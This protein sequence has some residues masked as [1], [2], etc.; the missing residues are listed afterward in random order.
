MEGATTV[1]LLLLVV[2][3]TSMAAAL[4]PPDWPQYRF[5]ATHNAV[6]VNPSVPPLPNARFHTDNEIK[7]NPVIVGNRLYVG[8]HLTGGLFAFNVR[9]VK[10]LW[11]DN[12]PWFRHAPNW[13]H[14]DMI[15]VAGRIFVGYGNR[16]FRSAQVRGTGE[17]GVLALN[18][19]TGATVWNHPT[20]G[21]V[22]PTPAYW[23]GALYVATGGGQLIALDPRTGRKRWQL[24]LPGWVSMSSPAIYHGRLYVGVE[25]A[26]VGV[27]LRTHKFLWKYHDDATFTDVPPAVSRDGKTVVITG[28]KAYSNTSQ[29]E[30]KRYPLAKGYLQFIYAFNAESGR[31]LWKHLMGNGPRQRDDTAGTPT[32]AGGT[33]YVGSP[34]THAF[35]AYQVATG[36]LLWRAPVAAMVKGAPAV[37]AGRVYFGDIAGFL[38]VLNASTGNPLHRSNG[39][40]IAPL[41]L[42]GS[43]GGCRTAL[44]PNGPVIIDQDVFV[45]S[46]DG[47]VYRISIP[48]WLRRPD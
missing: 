34:Y 42:G 25:N 26:V 28:M 17:S 3:Q 4:G 40:A 31:L 8:N 45:A 14:S 43:L 12:Y 39:K 44:A 15:A 41:K 38:H 48:G 1:A 22:M 29:A 10:T 30:R 7:A 37:A 47:N 33:V 36:Q 24:Q 46:A 13:V 2:A 27:N 5:S 16:V 32:I 9:R 18:P 35:F 19:K 20:I 11:D 6:Y 23:N 21:E